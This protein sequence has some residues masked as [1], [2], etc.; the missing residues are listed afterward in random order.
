M[1]NME[2]HAIWNRIDQLEQLILCQAKEIDL[3]RRV[4]SSTQIILQNN[5]LTLDAK[6][7]G[8][9]MM[10]ITTRNKQNSV[11]EVVPFRRRPGNFHEHSLSPAPHSYQ[12]DSTYNAT[13]TA[14]KINHN[15]NR[16]RDRLTV[17]QCS[18][19]GHAFR[20]RNSSSPTTQE[21]YTMNP[22]VHPANAIP[23]VVN[24][25][26]L[27]SA[28]SNDLQS[29]CANH[30]KSINDHSRA[31]KFSSP[32][33][34]RYQNRGS[35]PPNARWSMNPSLLT[36]GDMTTKTFSEPDFNDQDQLDQ[37][38]KKR[39]DR[40]SLIELITCFCPCFSMC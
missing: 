1:C 9:S 31:L 22:F 17:N 23:P 8:Q 26:V 37:K 11:S 21:N 4:V 29:I 33:E 6:I 24:R 16:F 25:I 30:E 34:R 5:G 20:H 32:M 7:V 15:P 38:A 36:A 35:L 19:R 14:N 10:A 3:L 40:F 18:N 39:A 27:K 13:T 2:L 28:T 12:H